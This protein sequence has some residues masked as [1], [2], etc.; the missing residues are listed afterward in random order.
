MALSNLHRKSGTAVSIV[1]INTIHETTFIT[2]AVELS[3]EVEEIRTMPR[4]SLEIYFL[5]IDKGKLNVE[6][7]VKFNSESCHDLIHK[8]PQIYLKCYNTNSDF[9][10]R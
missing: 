10:Y 5:T 3:V 7:R 2:A 6:Y 8:Y 4:I 9:S 1:I